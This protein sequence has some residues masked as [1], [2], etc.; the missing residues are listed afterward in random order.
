ME[1]VEA[2]KTRKRMCDSF[3]DTLD[4]CSR[5]PLGCNNNGKQISCKD[6]LNYYPEESEEILAKW[7]AE[8]P[9]KT[10]KDVF[11]EA[12]PNALKHAERA[13]GIPA[14]CPTKVGYPPICQTDE[15]CEQNCIKCWNQ[16]YK[17]PTK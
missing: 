9:A 12:F 17:E 5:C 11:N 15:C 16:E 4:G 2:M 10:L 13:P 6:L 7:N 14:I 3:G 1:F 8:H